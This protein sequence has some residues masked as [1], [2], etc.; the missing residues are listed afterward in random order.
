MNIDEVRERFLKFFEARGHKLHPSDSLIP[1]N[2]PSLLFTGA[3]M[4]QFKDMF[5][6]RTTLSS[7]RAV[8]CQKCLRT[9]DLE[10]VGRSS[11]HHTFFEMLG[12]F[13]FGD[14]FKAEA[15]PWHW[16]LFT[17]E[18][19]IPAELLHVSVYTED[20]EAALIWRDTVGVP[21]EKIKRFGADENFWPAN[22][23]TEGPNGPCGPCSEIYYDFGPEQGCG[24]PDCDVG[25][26]CNRYVEIGNL[27]FTQF[28]RQEDGSLP[29]LPQ[30]NI[31]TGTGLERL[32][33]VLQGV[34]SNFDID[35]FQPILA[36]ERDILK[37]KEDGSAETITRL[38]RIADHA[39]ALVFCIADNA[40][41]SNEGR[42][43]VVRRILRTALRDGVKLGHDAAFLHRLVPEVL[44]VMK[45][46]YPDAA[47]RRKTIENIVKAEEEGFLNTLHRG[48]ALLEEKIAALRKDGGDSLSG[49]DAF[50]LYDTFGFPIELTEDFSRE[51]G[52]NVDRA[53]F[54][55]IMRRK[56]ETTGAATSEDIF[57]KGTFADLK[58]DREPKTEFLG[59]GVPVADLDRAVEATVRGIIRL[60]PALID[61]Y[62][63]S[64]GDLPAVTML[65]NAGAA[66]DE[67]EAGTHAAV[68]LDRTPFYGDAGGQIG[69]VGRLEFDGGR[70][71]VQ[72]TKQPD[73]YFF[74]LVRV[75]K[76]T[77]RTGD[78]VQ[79]RIDAE[80]RLDI[81]RHHTATHI[82]Q[83]ALRNVLGTHVEQAG[84]V[85][86]PDRLRFD[87]T[88]YEAM[89]AEEIRKVEDWCNDVILRDLP[90][91]KAEMPLAEAKKK[92]AIAFFG[93]KYGETVRVVSVGISIS[94]ELCGGTH[95]ERTGTIGQMRIVGESS[96]QRGVRRI[97]AV[98][99]FGALEFSRKWEDELD[100][101]AFDLRCPRPEVRAKVRKLQQDRMKQKGSLR[102]AAEILQET[103]SEIGGET[104]ATA[105]ID[106]DAA[107]MRKRIDFYVK[108]ENIGG[109]MLASATGAK[110]LL[111][112]GVNERLIKEK[113]LKAGAIVRKIAN[114]LG[115]SGGGK[116]HMAQGGIADESK[117]DEAFRVFYEIVKEALK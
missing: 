8:S 112:V 56:S 24:A 102:S 86:E 26:D 50:L 80:R 43:Y 73:G 76:G 20:E 66:A 33:A 54:E 27:V 17:R 15:I 59:Y 62:A 29:P 81:M 48:T 53:R 113:K 84:S 108:K 44:D 36:A 35:A 41:P 31:D 42:G 22:A 74:H 1:T 16:E 55:E 34:H 25:C 89:T 92:G 117:I 23:P 88:H 111:I 116:D 65:L 77:L 45:K 7:K 21:E 18:F 69:D 97:E 10:K 106:A 71:D 91:T 103:E 96:I 67:A 60:E 64:K 3:G 63:D 61:A 114:L 12:N 40:L 19:Q 83:A 98:A 39:R 6:G 82:L 104:F 4:N 49:E 9:G 105:R 95:L 38:R 57:G 101:I 93:E 14:Y 5:L 2:D 94:A 72:E 79:A 99:G 100:E 46:Q 85:V 110:P 87:F 30:R 115:G 37:V 58:K 68:L 78:T 13:S 109:A 75:V 32:A 70:A 11:G 51:Q 107:E 28:D 90:V 47:K 52:V